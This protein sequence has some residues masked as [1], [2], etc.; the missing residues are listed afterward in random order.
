L[1]GSFCSSRRRHTSF[2]RD[3][4]SDVCSS[5]LRWM[6]KGEI[7]GLG[8]M[9]YNMNHFHPLNELPD[10]DDILLIDTATDTGHQVS[11]TVH[12]A[13][14]LTKK[15]NVILLD[16]WYYSPENKSVKKAPSDLSKDF[17]G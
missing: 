6:Y 3:W 8:D 13:F 7:I 11:A 2:S 17:F 1:F 15:R 16:T 14:A 4:S 5:D 10:D 12:C 9:V